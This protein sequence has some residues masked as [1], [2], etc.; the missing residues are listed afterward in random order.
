MSLQQIFFQKRDVH[1]LNRKHILQEDIRA[2]DARIAEAEKE[3]QNMSSGKFAEVTKHVDK[4]GL[5]QATLRG[6]QEALTDDVNVRVE[7]EL[8]SSAATSLSVSAHGPYPSPA[9]EQPPQRLYIHALVA[10]ILVQCCRAIQLATSCT[11]DAHNTR[12]C[13]GSYCR[14][15]GWRKAQHASNWRSYQMKSF[16]LRYLSLKELPTKAKAEQQL[17]MLPL[18]RPSVSLLVLNEEMVVM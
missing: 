5:Q 17:P 6:K 9:A 2:Q 12:H 18:K 16:R 3:L 8:S 10:D 1:T 15:S 7:M 13:V 4:L 14:L 11:L